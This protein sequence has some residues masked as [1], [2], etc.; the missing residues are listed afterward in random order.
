VRANLVVDIGVGVEQLPADVEVI[1]LR[2]DL[3]RGGA[4][5]ALAG[6][7]VGLRSQ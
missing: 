3:E 5:V 1:L 2:R 4:G 6:M 7:D